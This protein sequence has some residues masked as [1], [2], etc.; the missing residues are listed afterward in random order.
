[1]KQLNSR[2]RLLLP[3]ALVL[4]ALTGA[5]AAQA[6]APAHQSTSAVAYPQGATLLPGDSL[7]FF[8]PTRPLS[9]EQCIALARERSLPVQQSVA[10]TLGSALQLSRGKS[11][12]LP[13]VDAGISQSFDLGRSADRT[14]VMQNRSSSSTSFSVGASME[15]FSGLRRPSQIKEAHLNHQAARSALNA[16]KEEVA[17]TTAGYYYNLLYKQSVTRLA[18]E[19]I[20]LTTALA[21]QAEQMVANGK[22]SDAKLAE[23]QAQLAS[24]QVALVQAQND[25]ELAGLQ[26]MQLLQWPDYTHPIAIQ[27][28]SADHL[29]Q[30]ARA[31]AARG[32]EPYA[33]ALP[34]NAALQ[35]ALL[36][37]ESAL[38]AVSTAK[39]GYIPT[40]SM[41]AG[42][43]NSYY[44]LMDKEYKGL[45]SSFADQLNAN[46]R[47]Y[48]GLS[49]RIPI[50]DALQTA[51]SVRQAKLNLLAA[52]LRER[53]TRL[54]LESEART[55]YLNAQAAYRKIEAAQSAARQAQVAYDYAQVSYTAGRI[56]TYDL[57]Q[58]KTKL[59]Q[60]Q[61]E[62]LQA[63]YDFIYKSYLLRLYREPDSVR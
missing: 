62:A 19:Q 48:V 24:E 36:S 57:S 59:F 3:G 47:F 13:S 31:E 43:G 9:L 55:A 15:L 22:W 4:Y 27:T 17:R 10:D 39:S 56:S 52:D 46:G 37:K 32:Y 33:R 49:L 26:L 20:T 6:Q 2:I 35:S 58:A 21:Q 50:F 34:F 38:Q 14:G 25:Q 5:S 40:L 45:N 30:E 12:Y 42:Y 1:M 53:E 63:Q 51:Q 29:I 54:R 41:N 8:D 28:P 18:A 23:V 44:Y 60:A 61:I 16:Q 7:G 11:A